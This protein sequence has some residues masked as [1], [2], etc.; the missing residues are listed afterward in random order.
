MF[1]AEGYHLK[2][3]VA[4]TTST[5]SGVLEAA[6]KL[7][8]QEHVFAVIAQSGFTFAAAQ[9]LTSHGV[10]VIGA[11]VDANEWLTSKNMFS[12]YGYPNFSLVET[13]TGQ[14]LK[15]LGATNFG[16]IGYSVSP[17]SAEAAKSA[18][19]SAQL[20]GV[21]VGY[22]NAQLPLGNNVGPLVLAMKSAG[23]DSFAPEIELSTAFLILQGLRQEGIHVKVP[24]MATGYGGDLRSA[25][26]ATE[27]AAQGSYYP[28]PFEPVELNSPATQK[29]VNAMSTHAGISSSQITNDEV[30]GYM[31]VDGFV[32]G[33][34]AAGANPTQS[35]FI[36]AMLTI[37]SYNGAGLY[38][39]H[40]MGFAMDQRGHGSTGADNCQWV[41]Q[42]SG[43]SFH[44][45]QGAEPICGTVAPGKTVS[46]G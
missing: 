29:L 4:D 1:N 31:S 46:A 2:Y 34:K 39:S 6:Q 15:L 28:L 40:T 33:L 20:A 41:V 45:V 24:L 16:A 25:G 38:G 44:P 10:P 9:F 21:K 7:V 26:P 5:P 42:W 35:Q 36:D 23:V 17:S 3:V 22:L 30:L 13:T 12:I 11:D 43:S 14:L 8:D 37:R 32:A 18:A 19:V 27:Q